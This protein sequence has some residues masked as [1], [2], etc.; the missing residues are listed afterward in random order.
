M[1]GHMVFAGAGSALARPSPPRTGIWSSGRPLRL[2]TELPCV[3]MLLSLLL[4]LGGYYYLDKERESVRFPELGKGTVAIQRGSRRSPS[5]PCK[6]PSPLR[7]APRPGAGGLRGTS[8]HGVLPGSESAWARPGVSL[9]AEESADVTAQADGRSSRPLWGRH[10]L[11]AERRGSG[12]LLADG[13]A[14]RPTVRASWAR[15][16]SRTQAS[17]ASAILFGGVAPCKVVTSH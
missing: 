8:G 9:V 6:A 16:P 5:C 3:R 13:R 2:F 15:A 4:S 17:L 1:L 14:A 7:G 11:A 12:R 10:L